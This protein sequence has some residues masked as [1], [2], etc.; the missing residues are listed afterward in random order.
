MIYSTSL[1]LWIVWQIS[2]RRHFNWSC[3]FT[4]KETSTSEMTGLTLN[5]L[6]KGCPQPISQLSSAFNLTFLAPKAIFFWPG[7]NLIN[8]LRTRFFVWKCFSLV[9]FWQKKDFCTK[10]T[11]VKRVFYRGQF[12]Q[13]SRSSFYACRSRKCKKT[14]NLTV[15]LDLFWSAWVKTALRM[16]MKLTT[17]SE[18]YL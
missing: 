1:K 5:L 6:D 2:D 13:H 10:N 4:L 15:F 7:V 12:Y 9:T 18:S 3:L 8:I 11:R 14:N 17:E 16:L